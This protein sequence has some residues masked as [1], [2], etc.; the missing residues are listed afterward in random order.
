MTA[1]LDLD[2]VA[3]PHPKALAQ[4]L[5]LRAALAAAVQSHQPANPMP[6]LPPDQPP[7]DIT[8]ELIEGSEILTIFR[9]A[10]AEPSL[11]AR[12]DPS[13]PD[14]PVE[15]AIYCTPENLA[16]A[17]TLAIRLTPVEVGALATWLAAFVPTT[18]A[19]DHA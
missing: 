16:N 17:R 1:H 2:D 13:T 12:T 7:P 6:F 3:A 15:I 4:L 10:I 8:T 9:R 14:A 5:E 18:P 19:P 11:I